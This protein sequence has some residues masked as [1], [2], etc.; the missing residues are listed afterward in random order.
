MPNQ[1]NSFLSKYFQPAILILLLIVIWQLF[2]SNRSDDIIIDQLNKSELKLN[3]AISSLEDSEYLIDS[4]KNKITYFDE[5]SKLLTLERDSLLLKFKRET[6][7]NWVS[8]QE[9]IKKQK[10]VNAEL[11]YLRNKSKDFE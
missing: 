8:L 7:I 5:K 11:T 3:S 4:L 2:S 9:I 6:A 1:K 10:A